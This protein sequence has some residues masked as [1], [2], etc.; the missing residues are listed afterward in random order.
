MLVVVDLDR[1]RKKEMLP[2]G[3]SFST[4]MVTTE[5]VTTMGIETLA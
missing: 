4:Q 1:N 3:Q 2:C 5:V